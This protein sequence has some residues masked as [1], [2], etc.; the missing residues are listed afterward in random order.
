MQIEETLRSVGEDSSGG[1][2]A[3]WKL[4][5]G[6]RKGHWLVETLVL[7][8]IWA[9]TEEERGFLRAPTPGIKLFFRLFFFFQFHV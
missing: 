1:V 5:W 3:L 4:I 7:F 9:Q 2:T 8:P 6:V